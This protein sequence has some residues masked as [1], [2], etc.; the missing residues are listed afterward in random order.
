MGSILKPALAAAVMGAFI[1]L[2]YPWLSSV[3]GAK[4]AALIMI[5]AGAALYVITLI[6]VHGFYREDIVMLPKGEK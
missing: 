1:L 4:L 5:C 3:V 6:A 2:V